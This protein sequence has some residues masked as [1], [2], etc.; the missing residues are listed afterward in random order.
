MAHAP[1]PA[2]RRTASRALIIGVVAIVAV[3][4]LAFSSA[5][6]GPQ[7][8]DDWAAIQFNATIKTLSPL[9]IP[10]H[11]PVNTAVS[12]RP[13]VNF[14]LALNVALNRSLGLDV[15]G[16]AGSPLDTTSFHAVN[17]LIH[18]ACGLLLLGIVRRTLRTGTLAGAWESRADAIAALITALWL[19]HP[20]QTESVDYI[21]QR[22]ELLVGFF[23]LATLYC[24]IR[25]WDA[26]T[27]SSRLRWY[28]TGVAA[29]LLGMASKEVMVTA[30]LMVVLYDRAFRLDSWRDLRSPLLR[31]RR[32]F[33]GAL[34]TTLVLLATIVA[35]SPRGT[36][37]SFTGAIP[38]YEYL[39]TQGWA[40]AHYVRLAVV[41]VG[42]SLDYVSTPIAHWR[43]IPGLVLLTALALIT[44]LAWT[45]ASRW[46]WLAFLGTWFFAILAPSSSVLPV[47]TEVAAERRMYLPLAAVLV[48]LVVGVVA[49]SDRFAVPRQ[50]NG[51]AVSRR[52]Q[53]LGA[54]ACAVCGVF[55]V[56][57]FERGR[58]YQSPEAIWRDATM[59]QPDDARAWYNLGVM[60]SNASTLR[61]AEAEHDFRQ[62][63]VIDSTY[64]DALIR[65]ALDE[66]GRHEYGEAKE[67]LRLFPLASG[68][69]TVLANLGAALVSNGDTT[70]AML[71]LERA[72]QEPSSVETLEEYGTLLLAVGRPAAAAADFE[73]AVA[74]FPAHDD[75]RVFLGGMLIEQHNPADARPYLEEVVR[76]EPGS[77]VG[78]A[79]LSL[80]DAD[81]GHTD[82]AIQEAARAMA[83]GGNDPHTCF[84]A[85]RAMLHVHQD[86][87]ADEYLMRAVTLD[88]RASDP[89][90]ELGE[91][92]MALGR[93]AE[94]IA[95][96]KRALALNPNDSI[97]VA[98]LGRFR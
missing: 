82:D 21:V 50:A 89:I 59:E 40:I 75:V 47:L 11:P 48:L 90:T 76:R 9:S 22:T 64:A 31:S 88:P 53:A 77:G 43:G 86:G 12:G 24:S 83:L 17:L 78:F 27:A 46:G 61:A 84:F 3:T 39:H 73:R 96:F 68:N 4:A 94:A 79:L 10:L 98:R 60:V 8:F 42:L 55:A 81:L 93:M 66:M 45:R 71:A 41:P 28:A 14:T 97:A 36:S 80:A 35:T 1:A 15:S 20:L 62:A 57:T 6:R 34:A 69:D 18:I 25:A 95:H 63:L 72:V 32:W 19:L 70:G 33:Y 13:V 26:T 51:G 30:P 67:H 56:L 54:M 91:A 44:I 5:L 2:V 74:M 29:C 49:G 23:Y 37:A 7:L 16:A 38:W 87:R 65:V 85:G 92:E 52:A 58:L